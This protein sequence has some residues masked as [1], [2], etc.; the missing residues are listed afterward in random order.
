MEEQ[1][2]LRE[3]LAKYH[4]VFAIGVDD[5]GYIEKVKHDIYH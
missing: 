5:L 2:K 4:D 3:L 1:A